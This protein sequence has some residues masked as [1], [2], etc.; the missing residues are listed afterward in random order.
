MEWLTGACLIA[1][2][3]RIAKVTV[4]SPKK[5]ALLEQSLERA[6]SA[7][8]AIV[9]DI[10]FSRA[11]SVKENANSFL[12]ARSRDPFVGFVAKTA[13]RINLSPGNN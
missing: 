7:T 4:R 11:R 13:T 5:S 10:R 6:R 3:L 9:R 2:P 12:G 1:T 8:S